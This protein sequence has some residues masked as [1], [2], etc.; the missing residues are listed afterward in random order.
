MQVQIPKEPPEIKANQLLR[1]IV[2]HQPNL[3][4]AVAM[5]GKNGE[6]VAEFLSHLRQGLIQMYTKTPGD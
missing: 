6:A 5:T 4:P 3:L 2:E 1:H